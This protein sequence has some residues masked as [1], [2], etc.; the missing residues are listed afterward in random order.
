MKRLICLVLLNLLSNG[1]AS[2]YDK[3]TMGWYLD[4]HKTTEGAQVIELQLSALADGLSW[5]NTTYEGKGFP[6]LYCSPPKLAF[7]GEMLFHT[8][9]GYIEDHSSRTIIMAYKANK[10]GFFLLKALE[11]MFPCK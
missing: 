11:E 8:L 2:A 3:G 9:K 10:V 6:R 1:P 7:N 4:F 5:A